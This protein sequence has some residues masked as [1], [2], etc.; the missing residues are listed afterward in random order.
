MTGA[1]ERRTVVPMSI[2]EW[3]R[4]RAVHRAD[5]LSLRAEHSRG[6]GWLDYRR[7]RRA[8]KRAI[9]AER[10]AMGRTG[11]HIEPDKA[12]AKTF[13]SPGFFGGEKDRY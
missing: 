9:R 10:R 8:S 12:W 11:Q 4:R 7:R 2:T 1:R 13:N 6:D 5:R 3:R